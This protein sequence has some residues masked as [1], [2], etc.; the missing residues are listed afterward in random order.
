MKYFTVE[1]KRLYDSLDVEKNIIDKTKK[2]SEDMDLLIQQNNDF[3]SL[4]ESCAFDG[5]SKKK[6]DDFSLPM[7]RENI[8]KISS[9]VSCLFESFDIAF[10][11]LLPLLK[12][13]KE[14]DL[15]LEDKYNE[16]KLLKSFKED[17]VFLL[18][19]AQQYDE[20]GNET[21]NYV[22]QKEKLNK[23][24]LDI[25]SLEKEIKALEKRLDYLVYSCKNEIKI[26]RE[27]KNMLKSIEIGNDSL[28]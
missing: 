21:S 8:K 24:N 12:K 3:L 25:S 26:I 13:V 18:R 7:I 6:L 28:V 11:K 27:N 17:T 2:F 15:I 4:Y 14:E 9:N 16:L 22:T 5:V 10:N 19:T 23:I 20:S 1:F